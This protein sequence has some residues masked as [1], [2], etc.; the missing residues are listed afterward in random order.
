MHGA[1]F[2][3]P[4]VVLRLLRAGADMTLRDVFG[5]TA[6]QWAKEKGRAECV[7]AFKTYL[8]EVAAVR[9]K[10]ASAEAGG[11][12]AVVGESA[13]ASASSVEGGAEVEPSGGGAARQ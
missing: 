11:A 5:K 13:A 2:N 9:S 8:G 3:R 12:G 10:A 6:L 7:Q 1:C 4:A